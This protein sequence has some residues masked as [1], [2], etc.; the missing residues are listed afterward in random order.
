MTHMNDWQ[1]QQR[2]QAGPPT[3]GV[4]WGVVARIDTTGFTRMSVQA[5][6][7]DDAIVQAADMLCEWSPQR[8]GW[9]DPNATL[10]GPVI[11]FVRGIITDADVQRW[12]QRY[13]QL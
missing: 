12:H 9:P 4:L 3:P 8:T 5:D 11:L 2:R 7:Y 13:G 1:D 6:D 10:T